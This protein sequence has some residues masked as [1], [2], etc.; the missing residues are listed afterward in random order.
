MVFELLH[1]PHLA[2]VENLVLVDWIV[3]RSYTSQKIF[4]V[5]IFLLLFFICF[6]LII[7]K[8]AATTSVTPF[9]FQKVFIK[10]EKLAKY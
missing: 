7:E 1:C 10:S 2:L 3:I 8:I 6:Y 5:F 4:F 9:Y